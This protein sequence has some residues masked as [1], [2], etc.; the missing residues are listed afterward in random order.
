[1]PEY[2]FVTILLVYLTK[3]NV[4]TGVGDTGNYVD[5]CDRRIVISSSTGAIAKGRF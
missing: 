2:R 5:F 4:P 3:L 1:M